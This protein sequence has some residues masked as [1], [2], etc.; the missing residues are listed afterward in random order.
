M[1]D[2]GLGAYR[3]LRVPIV[4]GWEAFLTDWENF[5]SGS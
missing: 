5:L 1:N 4:M 3:F 2:F